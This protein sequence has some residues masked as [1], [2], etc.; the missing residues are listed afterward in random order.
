MSSLS[1]RDFL[2]IGS[3]VGAG[4]VAASVG[5]IYLNLVSGRYELFGGNLSEDS[6]ANMFD[7]GLDDSLFTVQILRRAGR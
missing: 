3:V 2:K 4:A 5:Y 1:R 7:I 6:K